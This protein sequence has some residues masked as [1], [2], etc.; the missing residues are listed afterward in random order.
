MPN[1]VTPSLLRPPLRTTITGNTTLG[2][3]C[4]EGGQGFH[5]AAEAPRETAL[6]TAAVSNTPSTI[7]LAVEVPYGGVLHATGT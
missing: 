2:T 1:R 5:F 7:H 4:S 3:Q 6:N